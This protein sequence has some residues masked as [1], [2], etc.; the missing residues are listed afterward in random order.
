[1]SLLFAFIYS[2]L[3]FN[4]YMHTYDVLDPY[5]YAYKWKLFAN[6]GFTTIEQFIMNVLYMPILIGV[7]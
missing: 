6:N 1:M 3:E 7:S 5:G 2:I 4:Y